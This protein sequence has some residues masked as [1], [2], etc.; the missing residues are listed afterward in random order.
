LEETSYTTAEDGGS[1]EVCAVVVEGVL[2]RSAEVSISTV[3]GS[4]TGQLVFCPFPIL[5][6]MSKYWSSLSGGEDYTSITTVLTFD[7][8]NTRGCSDV[9]I[10]DDNIYEDD[11]TFS[12]TLTTEDGDVTLE[13]DSGVVIITDEDGGLSYTHVCYWETSNHMHVYSSELT[14][15][16]VHNNIFGVEILPNMTV[17]AAVQERQLCTRTG[18]IVHYYRLRIS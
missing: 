2:E 4:A 17:M 8:S 1:V 15:F 18:Y 10:T 3:D 13:P 11:E 12:V 5:S 7:G 16:T 9:P 6:G 14:L